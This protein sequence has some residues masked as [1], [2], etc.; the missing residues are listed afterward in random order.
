MQHQKVNITGLNTATL[1]AL[2][3]EETINLLKEYKTGDIYAKEKLIVGNLKLVLAVLKKININQNIDINDLFQIGCIG[4][5]KA[6]E[7]FNL[8]LNL[9]FSTYAIPMIQGEIRRYLR[10][11]TQLKISRQIKDIAYKILKCKDEFINKYD[12][13]PTNEEICQILNITKNQIDEAICS[14]NNVISIFDPIYNENGDSLNLIDQLSD[15][16]NYHDKVINYDTLNEGL[17]SLNPM[18]KKIIQKRYY[19]G[20]TQFEIAQELSISQAQVSRM[21]KNAIEEL[22]KLF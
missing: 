5:I 17:K 2:K 14:T 10:D 8:E 4:L 3:K 22:K 21:E 12:K 7:N 9:S 19:D 13:E 11:N 16:Y 18:L 15:D 20:L 1:K 6:I